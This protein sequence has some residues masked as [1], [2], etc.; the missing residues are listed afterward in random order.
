LSAPCF[1]IPCKGGLFTNNWSVF[2]FPLFYKGSKG[3]HKVTRTPSLLKSKMKDGKI[4][5]C[6][7]WLRGFFSTLFCKIIGYT[8]LREVI[9]NTDGGKGKIEGLLGGNLFKTSRVAQ[10]KFPLRLLTDDLPSF[11]KYKETNYL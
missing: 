2:V 3:I 10:L 6:R 7:D 11:V 5:N 1:C 9:H 8:F 4:R